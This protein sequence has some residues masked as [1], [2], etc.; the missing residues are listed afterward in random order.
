M[1]TVRLLH[2]ILSVLYPFHSL[3]NEV[4]SFSQVSYRADET[5][6]LQTKNL[7]PQSTYEVSAEARDRAG[8]LWKSSALFVAN[9]RGK[10]DFDTAPISG[11]YK[12]GH[13]Q[14]LFW[15]MVPNSY[16]LD[17]EFFIPDSS[18]N[19]DVKLSRNGR[20]LS[21]DRTTRKLSDGRY[22]VETSRSPK[23][24][25]D[26][27]Y[28]EGAENLP[29]V[30]LLGGSEGGLGCGEG[31]LIS[32][33]G[34][35]VLCLAYFKAEGLAAELAQV[36]LEYIEANIKRILSHPSV[37]P[38]RVY[39]WGTSKGAELA[40]LVASRMP[41]VIRGVVAVVPSHLVWQG[42]KEDNSFVSSWS[43]NGEPLAF[44]PFTYHAQDFAQPPF[45]FRVGYE[46]TLD[47][48]HD[49]GHSEIAVEQI[50]G[51]ILLVSG[52]DDQVWPSSIM[53]EKIVER[54]KEKS[55]H[56][57]VIHLKF[58]NAGHFIGLPAWPT[59]GRIVG[60]MAAGGTTDADGIASAE[61]RP[62]IMQFLRII[63]ANK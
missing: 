18:Y 53:S 52:T 19:I 34:F 36:P 25:Y 29:V 1:K 61:S 28:S 46:R 35:A 15:S 3:A 63:S 32:S 16:R 24:Y 12:A 13:S 20:V 30:V 56:H 55:F 23:G 10:I 45:R 51:P 6:H 7:A 27:V 41:D 62:R 44:A 17:R 43:L 57:E 48:I 60:D 22:S 21:S 31:R 39:I 38:K 50:A 5:I 42:L 26:F 47:T 58:E 2:A 33:A 37:D 40:L 8:R 4:I 54:L 49:L 11:S 59:S 9:E 14:G